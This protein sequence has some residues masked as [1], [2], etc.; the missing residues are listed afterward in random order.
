MRR[1]L[2]WELSHIF[3]V[4]QLLFLGLL[5]FGDIGFDHRGRLGFDFDHL[6]C[7]SCTYIMLLALGLICALSERSWKSALLQL[8]IPLL[9]YGYDAWPPPRYDAEKYQHWVGKPREEVEPRLS[10]RGTGSGREKI[11]EEEELEFVVYRGMTIYYSAK[12]Q[13]V[14]RIEPNE[15]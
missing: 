1:K 4:C 15:R 3:F 11:S 7:F 8:A 12:H 9:W 14:S 5:A 13:S 2:D 6:V 10:S